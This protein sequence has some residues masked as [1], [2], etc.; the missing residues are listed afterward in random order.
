[1]KTLAFVAI[2]VLG[3]ALVACAAP[4]PTE[5]PTIE[6]P[7]VEP[8]IAAPTMPPATTEA[9]T[10]TIGADVLSR[11]GN[12]DYTVDGKPY[13]LANGAYSDTTGVSIMMFPPAAL[14]D[15]NADA[16]DDAAVLLAYSG[17]GSGTFVYLA[18]VVDQDGSFVNTDTVLLEDRV[19]VNDMAIADGAITLNVT[20]HGPHDPMCCPTSVAT[21]TYV[22][23]D[24]K[25]KLT[26][27]EGPPTAPAP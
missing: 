3:L 4:V 24:G 8:P 14:G 25:L 26:S 21:W 13:T 1:M 22:L 15:L 23:E 17:G 7:T 19:Q 5:V 18:A 16:V 11:L 20:T 12:M 6:P 27:P 9:V 10:F 2:A